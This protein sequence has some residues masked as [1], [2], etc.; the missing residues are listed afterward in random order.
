MSGA[1]PDLR[2][3]EHDG[4]GAPDSRGLTGTDPESGRPDTP[5]PTTRPGEKPAE[6][7]PAP[8][9][10]PQPLSSLSSLLDGSFEGGPMC[11]ADGNCG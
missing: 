9:A 7:A 2:A 6:A 8:S 1:D 11:D 4:P 10:A 5:S 3:V